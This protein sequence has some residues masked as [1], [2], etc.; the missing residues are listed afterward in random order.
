MI[1]GGEFMND[2]LE[3]SELKNNAKR[4]AYT[5]YCVEKDDV[6]IGFLSRKLNYE[7]RQLKKDM[8]DIWMFIKSL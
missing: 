1:L 3:H 8:F 5:L 6:L 4:L 7:P 2:E